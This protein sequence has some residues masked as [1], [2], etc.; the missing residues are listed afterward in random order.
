MSVNL[1]TP[2]AVF[3]VSDSADMAGT[4]PQTLT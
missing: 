2:I 4:K 3:M 1:S